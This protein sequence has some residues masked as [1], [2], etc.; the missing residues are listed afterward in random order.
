MITCAHTN[1][2]TST[3]SCISKTLHNKA[4][5]Y[6]TESPKWL[7]TL[8]WV[9]SKIQKSLYSPSY[10]H[11][12]IQN[13]SNLQ[14]FSFHMQRK[15]NSCPRRCTYSQMLLIRTVPAALCY[16]QHHSHFSMSIHDVKRPAYFVLINVWY[17]Y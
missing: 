8:I 16:V 3:H 11:W 9:N 5:A 12:S 1:N 2:S 10:M 6:N 15:I 17:N 7:I 4:S 13:R 14:G